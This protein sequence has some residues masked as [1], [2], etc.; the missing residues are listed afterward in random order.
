M[1]LLIGKQII[2]TMQILPNI[3][4]SKG[5]QTMKF[6][7]WIEYNRNIFLEKSYKIQNVLEKLAPDPFLKNQYCTYLWFSSLKFY[8]VCFY[9]E[10]KS[11]TIY[12]IMLKLRC[13]PFTFASCKT[14]FEKKRCGTSLPTSFS[15]W[16]LKENISHVMFYKPDQ[17]SS[18]NCLYFL[19]NWV[20]CVL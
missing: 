10:S 2:T 16:F 18:Y 1:T 6:D 12:Q 4:R 3:S 20:I 9:S 13:T 19:R 11:M 8:I 17:I 7:K 14:F 5:N 15:V